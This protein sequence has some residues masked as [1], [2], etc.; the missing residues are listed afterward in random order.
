MLPFLVSHQQVRLQIKIIILSILS[1]INR[2]TLTP[3]LREK[4]SEAM[5]P[6]TRNTTDG[7]TSLLL[8]ST[9]PD[10]VKYVRHTLNVQDQKMGE[11]C[12]EAHLQSITTRIGR[13][14]MRKNTFTRDVRQ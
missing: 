6:G 9:K 4:Y 2:V 14:I 13:L 10:L 1:T 3:V 7:I 11:F 8:S 5:E 12:Q